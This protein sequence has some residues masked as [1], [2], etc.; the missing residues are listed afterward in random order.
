MKPKER[1]VFIINPIAGNGYALSLAGKITEMIA[2][3]DLDAELVYSER[4]GHAGELAKTY[5]DKGCRYIIGVGGDGTINEIAAPLIGNPE[6]IIGVIAGGTGNDFIQITGFPGQ[7]GEEEWEAFFQLHTT[8]V[9]AGQCNDKIFLNGMGLGFDAQVAAENYTAPGEVKAGGKRKYIWHILKTLLFYKEQRM[10]V[11]SN[12]EQTETDCFINTIANGRRF[13]GGFY[14]TPKSLANDGLLDVCS[15]Q[16]L[17]LLQRLHIL[18]MVPKGTHIN[19]KHVRYYQTDKLSLEFSTEVPFHVDGELY[20]AR[21][22]EV[23]VLP[24]ALQIIY[25]PQ[26]KHYLQ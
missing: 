15:V 20:Y 25:N 22:F 6:V 9:D 1:W 11:L 8:T 5:A 26:G 10:T 7:F 14:L 4:R 13:A 18:P 23:K 21:H 17:S 16:K 2:K 24:Q 12:G 19:D 3:H